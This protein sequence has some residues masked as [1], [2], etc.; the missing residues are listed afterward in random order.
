[1]DWSPDGTFIA[2]EGLSSSGE[3]S[4]YRI[5]VGTA[6]VTQLTMQAW[7]YGPVISPDNTEILFAQE[8]D[9][10][11]LMK[12]PAAGGTVVRMSPYMNFNLTGGQ[13]GWDWSP[14]GSEIVFTTDAIPGVPTYP[15]VVIARILRSTTFP[16]SYDT[17]VKLV[18]RLGTNGSVQDRQPSWRP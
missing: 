8:N 15:G 17:D 10:W 5:E 11:T 9:I 2:F 18:G 13:A 3:R 14:D 6:A 16:D 7:D 12:V 1:M 4:I